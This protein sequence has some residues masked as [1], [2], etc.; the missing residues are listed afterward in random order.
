MTTF[1]FRN[2]ISGERL[3]FHQTKPKAIYHNLGA[4]AECIMLHIT[5]AI[6]KKLV[7]TAERT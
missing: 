1:L 3:F 4:K 2:L 7:F 6:S 5:R